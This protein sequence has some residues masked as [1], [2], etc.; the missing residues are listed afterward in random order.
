METEHIYL[1]GNSLYDGF[2]A[3]D[4]KNASDGTG[5]ISNQNYNNSGV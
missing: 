3:F 5:W 1:S 2:H 4:F